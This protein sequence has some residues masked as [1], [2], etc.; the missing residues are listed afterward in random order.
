MK[1]TPGNMA[2]SVRDRLK[3]LARTRGEN[4]DLMLVRYGIER[5]LYRLSRSPWEKNYVLK[6]AMLFTVWAGALHRETRDLDLMGFGDSSVGSL[7]ENFRAICAVAV[8]DD[9]L[10]FVDVRGETIQALQDYGGARLTVLAK[11]TTARITIQVDVAFGNRITPRARRIEFPVLLDFPAPRLRAYPVETVV[12]EKLQAMVDLGLR[13]GRLKDYFDL[14]HLGRTVRFDG[15]LL[16]QAVRATFIQRKTPIPLNEP[17]GLTSRFY[18][19]AARETQWRAFLRKV[20]DGNSDTALS[21]VVKFLRLFLLPLLKAA[22]AEAP[23]PKVW[24]PGGPWV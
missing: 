24:E 9:G 10:V 3:V 22:G 2:A 11:L 20:G 18:D 21:D 4:F 23:F 6:G 8:P 7:V 14:W 17:A 15:S 19:D 13:N 16:V 1:S 5:L 12:A